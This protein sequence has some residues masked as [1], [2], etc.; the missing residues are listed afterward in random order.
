MISQLMTTVAIVFQRCTV[1]KI[2]KPRVPKLTCVNCSY[3]PLPFNKDNFYGYAMS[4]SC[5]QHNT[6]KNL[7][8]LCTS[9]KA[10]L[11]GMQP[12]SDL[13]NRVTYKNVFCA[14]CNQASNLTYWNFSA[15][16]K[17]FKSHDIPRNRSLMLEF[18]MTKCAWHF[19]PP[20][21]HSG[22]VCL[23]VKENCPDPKLVNEEPLL[24]DL[25]SF[26]SFPVCSDFQP[27]NPHCDL[28][29][30]KDI[31]H[32]SCLCGGPYGT[33][34]PIPSLKIL[35]GFSSSSHSVQ[36]GERK[37]L[38]R[39]KVCP[40][41][42]VFD[43]FKEEC[44]ELHVPKSVPKISSINSSSSI[45]TPSVMDLQEGNYINCSYVEMN[46]SSVIRLSN[47]SIWIPL[48]KR[49]YNKEN[50]VINGSSLLLCT[51]FVY[52]ETETHVS[53]EILP[54]HILTYTGCALSMISLI[55]L[56]GIYIALPELRTLPGKNL[57]SLSCAM[58][59]YHIIFFLTGQT[60]KPKICLAVSVLLH[61]FLLSTFCW[62]GVMAFDVEKTFGAKGN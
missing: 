52:T 42:F 5:S 4:S 22:K 25:C 2:S 54:L 37:N 6:N 18:I 29:K 47:V 26:Y 45:D 33:G 24:R 3:N 62:M 1:A 51:D 32:Y 14:S 41:G 58:L 57:I 11:F 36:V 40:K 23:S 28:C 13:Q 15:S 46:I 38:V 20:F 48:H 61:Y 39:N 53:M 43:S 8:S 30:G 56:L 17:G 10:G 31:S 9:P 59:S 19:K 49:L 35:F 21:G 34:I 27:K 60:D 7:E 12:V 50:F 16:C 55:F 44:V